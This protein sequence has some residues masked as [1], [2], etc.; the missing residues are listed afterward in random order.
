[1]V[2]CSECNK[3]FLGNNVNIKY[4]SELYQYDKLV[5]K[6]IRSICAVQHSDARR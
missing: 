2:A 3:R 6:Y 1:M 5:E 4:T